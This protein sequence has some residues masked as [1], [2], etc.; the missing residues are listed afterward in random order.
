[1]EV[2]INNKTKSE[3]N[4]KIVKKVAQKFLVKNK[5]SN[6]GLSI[7]FV[8]DKIIREINKK[9]RKIDKATD[10]LSFRDGGNDSF[11]EDNF[12]GEIIIDYQQI[13]RQAKD[14]RNTIQEELV[15]IL[16]HGLL[17]LIGHDDKTEQQA[18]KMEKLGNEFINKNIKT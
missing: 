4:L 10:V 1:M 11:P 18:N 9:Y 14:K 17:H 3:I 16:V 7:V 6:Y 8:G 12:L 15:F 2:E 13:K 5:K